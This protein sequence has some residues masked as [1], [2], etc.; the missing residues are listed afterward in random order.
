MAAILEP[1]N[2]WVC[3]SEDL[4]ALDFFDVLAIVWNHRN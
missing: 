3:V 2:Y 1:I 4:L